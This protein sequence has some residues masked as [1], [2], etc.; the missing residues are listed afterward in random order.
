MLFGMVPAQAS[1]EVHELIR[2][3][4]VVEHNIAYQFAV[5][6]ENSCGCIKWFRMMHLHQGHDYVRGTRQSCVPWPLMDWRMP[7]I[8]ALSRESVSTSTSC[9]CEQQRAITEI[10]NRYLPKAFNSV[11][12]DVYSKGIASYFS[13]SAMFTLCTFH[14]LLLNSMQRVFDIVNFKGETIITSN[15]SRCIS[16][17]SIIRVRVAVRAPNAHLG[18]PLL[19]P[20]GIHLLGRRHLHR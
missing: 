15:R 20:K 12:K 18:V 2:S 10:G 1:G 19:V 16:E 17:I 5:P 8:Y 3:L 7:A 14:S 11:G 13:H 9:Q 6:R 4:Q